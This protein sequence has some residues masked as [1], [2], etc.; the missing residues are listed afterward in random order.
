MKHRLQALV[1][2]LLFAAM[3]LAAPPPSYPQAC[4][5]TYCVEVIAT[6]PDRPRQIS[7]KSDYLSGKQ[8]LVVDMGRKFMVAFSSKNVDTRLATAKEQ[9]ARWNR[10]GSKA[11]AWACLRCGASKGRDAVLGI[12]LTGIPEDYD[13]TLYGIDVCFWPLDMSLAGY[14]DGR[15]MGLGDKVCIRGHAP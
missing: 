15:T 8:T 12:A 1:L 7:V 3:A 10:A 9:E 2:L 5:P 14:G 13:L 6:T 4:A 11:T